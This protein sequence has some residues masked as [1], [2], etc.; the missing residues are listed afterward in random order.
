MT[1]ESERSIRIGFDVDGVV[2]DFAAGY[3]AIEQRLF[4]GRPGRAGEPEI[5]G[6][7]QEHRE[8]ENREVVD[9]PGETPAESHQPHEMRR[10]RDLIWKEIQQTRD[11]WATLDPIEEHGVRRIHQLMLQY[12]WEVFFITQRPATA[13]DTV[14]RQTQRWLV[15]QGFD[16]PSVLAIT[17]S[18]G[19]VSAALRLSYHVD[20]NPQN[21]IDVR[22]DSATKP[23]LILPDNDEVTMKSARTLGIGVTNS[24]SSCLDIL[25]K[26]T[27]AK[28]EPALLERLAELVGW[29]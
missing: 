2:A 11:F 1:R 26:A 17:G 24:L 3:R 10:R 29:R 7:A 5:E 8:T 22:A 14:Q 9:R 4:G 12:R 21:C 27:A 6:R 25:E 13:G 18:R 23:L 15:A 28:S 16:I 20:D 19:V